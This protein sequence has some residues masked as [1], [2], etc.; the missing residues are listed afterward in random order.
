[1]SYPDLPNNIRKYQSEVVAIRGLNLSDNTQ[2][3]DLCETRNI[4]CRR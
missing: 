2:D 4:S 1:M 3:G